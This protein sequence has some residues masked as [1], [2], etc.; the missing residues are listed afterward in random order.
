MEGVCTAL[1]CW[2]TVIWR[3]FKGWH[4]YLDNELLVH[5]LCL[6]RPQEALEP[7][8]RVDNLP[9]ESHGDLVGVLNLPE[10]V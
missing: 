7:I 6:A 5:L 10:L 9:Q 4:T 1:V 3:I 8:L 2:L